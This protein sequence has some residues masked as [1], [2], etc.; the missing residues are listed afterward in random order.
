MRDRSTLVVVA[1][2]D[3]KLGKHAV[4]QLRST[5]GSAVSLPMDLS[6]QASIRTFVGGFRA[7]GLPPL[8][9]IICNAGMQNVGTP[10]TTIDGYET[11]F[12]VNHLG[13]YLLVRMLLDDLE[14]AGRIVFVSSGTHDPKEKTGMPAP[15]YKGAFAAAHNLTAGRSAGLR[16]YTT[17][18]LCNVLCTYELSRRLKTSDD[19]RLRSI[20]VNAIDPGLMPATGLARSWPKPLRWVSRNI[21]PLSRLISSNVHTPQVSGARVAALA[22]GTAAAPGGR[23]FSNG[24]A[25]R[26][27]D[28]SYDEALQEELWVSG[29]KMTGLPTCSEASNTQR[30]CNVYR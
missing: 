14:G 1:C 26:S 13:H 6:N 27:P 2:R 3:P 11:T 5:G 4:E 28:M 22:V 15:V 20:E 24:K 12:A 9:A 7:A 16:R 25:V 30:N 17:S 18:K 10:Q 23:Y 8:Y 19:V 21:L 29:A